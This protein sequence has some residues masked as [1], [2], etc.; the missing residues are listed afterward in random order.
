VITAHPPK[1]GTKTG[2]D[3]ITRR[4]KTG[5]GAS[6]WCGNYEHSTRYKQKRPRRAFSLQPLQHTQL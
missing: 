5:D 4:E 2:Q 1:A 3:V 6:F